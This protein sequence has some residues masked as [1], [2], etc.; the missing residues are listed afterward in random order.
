MYQKPLLGV[1]DGHG[2]N[3]ATAANFVMEYIK[4]MFKEQKMDFTS[5]DQL[6]DL[7]DSSHAA[8]VKQESDEYKKSIDAYNLSGTT[9]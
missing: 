9:A 5:K 7:V 6:K 1:F 8:L 3:G 4:S 2:K